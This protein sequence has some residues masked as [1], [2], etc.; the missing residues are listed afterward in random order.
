[1][2]KP[3]STILIVLAAIVIAGG[4]FFAG[5]MYGHMF[6]FGPFWNNGA[7]YAP[8]QMMR[9]FGPGM[10]GRGGWDDGRGYG[11]GM[12]NGN[13]YGPGMMG[14]NGYGPGMMGRYG[15]NNVNAAPLTV[16]QAR[17]GRGAFELLV[18][19]ASQVVYPEHGANM[20]WNT[21]Y[22][23][24]NH[25][26]MMGGYGGMMGRYGWNGAAPSGNGP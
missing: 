1:M 25:Q 12:M 21:K 22:G 20:M 8:S 26:N 16:D 3:L 23:A 24:I 18:D 7:A 15:Y 2:S 6:A 11:P 10:M 13:G 14:G 9:G 4:L 5:T 19:P 17:T